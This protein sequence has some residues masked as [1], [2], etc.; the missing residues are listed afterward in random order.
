V[1]WSV[2]NAEAQGADW[3]S[4]GKFGAEASI[5]ATI[6]ISVVAY[7]IWKTD[8][9]GVAKELEAQWSAYP[10]GYGLKPQEF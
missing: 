8:R 10:D 2:F 5:F 7:L 6:V 9:L 4:G 3:I 1:K